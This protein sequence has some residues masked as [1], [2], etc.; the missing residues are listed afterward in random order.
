MK[1]VY[2]VHHCYQNA[3]V[4]TA[5]FTGGTT[6]Y[7]LMGGGINWSEQVAR[8]CFSIAASLLSAY[9][10]NKIKNFKDG[11]KKN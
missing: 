11:K 10:V 6:S 8:F 3:E 2:A 4:I 7:V 9:F 5:M 1:V